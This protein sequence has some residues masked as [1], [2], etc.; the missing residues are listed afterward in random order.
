MSRITMVLVAASASALIAVGVVALPAIGDSGDSGPGNLDPF[1]ACLRA[2]GLAD[3][4]SDPVALKQWLSSK[5]QSSPQ[6]VRS[7]IVACKA[8]TGG[9]GTDPGPSGPE[10]ADMISCV[11]SHGLDA[12]TD[13]DQFKRWVA[14]QQASNAD[15]VDR[16]IVACKMALDP[17]KSGKPAPAKPGECGGD[18]APADKP[19]GDATAT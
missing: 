8:Q 17:G 1:V 13:P 12:P 7:A 4:P 3:A 9:S 19:K 15:A 5:E 18:A 16:V 2:H 14:A 6:A 11:R 10:I